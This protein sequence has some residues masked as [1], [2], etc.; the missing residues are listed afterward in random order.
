MRE[1]KEEAWRLAE[2]QIIEERLDKRK[3]MNQIK[4]YLTSMKTKSK[5]PYQNGKPRDSIEK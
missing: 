4:N 2:Q 3:R 1:A 5:K